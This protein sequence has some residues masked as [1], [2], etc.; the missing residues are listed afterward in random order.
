MGGRPGGRGEG[1]GRTGGGPEGGDGRGWAA[2]PGLLGR[3]ATMASSSVWGLCLRGII[4]VSL[5]KRLNAILEH[6]SRTRCF[7]YSCRYK[8]I[9]DLGKSADSQVHTQTSRTRGLGPRGLYSNLG[10]LG[11]TPWEPLRL[12]DGLSQRFRGKVIGI[13]CVLRFASGVTE[14]TRNQPGL[15]VCCFQWSPDGAK[16]SAL[17]IWKEAWDV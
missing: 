5:D 11:A 13:I 2:G 14:A 16:G 17:R 3:S 10:S 1:W 6:Y 8:I 15:T 12:S 4:F 7:T 9:R